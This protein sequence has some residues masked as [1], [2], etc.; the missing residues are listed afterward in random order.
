V[1]AF[2]VPATGVINYQYPHAANALG[3]DVWIRTIE[4]HPGDR[5]V[6]HHVLAGIDDPGNDSQRTIRGQIGELGGYAPSKNYFAYPADSGILLRKDASF[7]F[8]MHVHWGEQTWDEMNVG[9]IRYRYADEASREDSAGGDSRPS[10][11]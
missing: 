9:W 10:V 2:N 1:P 6:V 8:Q 5:S 11:R 7:R 4:I 3:R